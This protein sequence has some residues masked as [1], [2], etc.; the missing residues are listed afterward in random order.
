VVL[1]LNWWLQARAAAGSAIANAIPPLLFLHTPCCTLT[2]T[3]RVCRLTSHGS[4]STRSSLGY[5]CG[6]RRGRHSYQ[7]V[8]Y[9][10][11]GYQGAGS[12]LYLA[13]TRLC[14]MQQSQGAG[15]DA[16]RIGAGSDAQRIGATGTRGNTLSTATL[17]TQIKWSPGVHGLLAPLCDSMRVPAQVKSMLQ[18]VHSPVQSIK[19]PLLEKCG[20]LLDLKRDDLIHPLISG[21]KWRK[22]K[23]EYTNTHTHI[24]FPREKERRERDR[25][26]RERERE[27]DTHTR[28]TCRPSPQM[29]THTHM[30]LV[31]VHRYQDLNA[32]PL[33]KPA[34]SCSV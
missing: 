31:Y 27:R 16:Q 1:T 5:P 23:S 22:L 20:V 2:L 3:V 10:G 8:G 14:A 29:Y 13:T 9:R 15:S 25:E 24:H 28:K 32:G 34:E 6:L 12:R 33:L 30:L 26:E 4:T 11:A 7:G 18:Q 21:N 17:N 19:D